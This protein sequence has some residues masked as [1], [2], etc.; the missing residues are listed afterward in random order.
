[1]AIIGNGDIAKA[2]KDKKDKLF[3]VSGVSNSQETR[4]SEFRREIDLLLDQDHENHIVYVSSLCV[5]ESDTRYARHKRQMEKLVKNFKTWTIIR[6][7]NITWGT[8]PHT[9][10]NFF[11]Q[12]KKRGE[13]IDVQDVYR[14]ICDQ[15]EFQYWLSKIPSWSCEMNIPGRRMKVKDIV[16]E[17]V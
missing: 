2:I 5:F 3:F 9:L 7:G 17:Y 1:M 11:K 14:Y 15:D 12:Q 6:L 13:K 16:K 8:N 4:A 10:I